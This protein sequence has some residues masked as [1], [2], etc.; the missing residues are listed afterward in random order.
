MVIRR[1]RAFGS[2]V[3]ATGPLCQD[4]PASAVATGA[5][6]AFIFRLISPMM[7]P[8]RRVS[9][10]QGGTGSI[11]TMDAPILDEGQKV[12]AL[13]DSI[14]R[15]HGISL[16]KDARILDFG[17]GSGRHTYEYLDA[18]FARTTGFDVKDYVRLRDPQDRRYF[19][20]AEGDGS[21]GIPFP[22]DTFDFITS[23][24]VFEHVLKPAEIVPEI[25]RVLK[26]DGVTL[27]VFPSRWRP[28]EPHIHVPFGG[29]IQARAWLAFWAHMGVRNEFQTGLSA[30]ETVSRNAA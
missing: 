4:T 11:E 14:L 28:V 12:V 29:A 26:P 19:A 5:A 23:T 6:A 25:A 24:S 10:R 9:L 2:S 13:N 7:S 15:R 21:D 8:R 20:F 3:D 16:P 30:R 27:H 18:G 22:D 17:C 1:A